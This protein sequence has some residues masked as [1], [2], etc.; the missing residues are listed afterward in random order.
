MEG[1]ENRTQVFTA[2]HTPLEIPHKPRDSHFSTAPTT[3]SGVEKTKAE[4]KPKT[5]AAA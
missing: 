4:A 3:A 5:K 1:G 2:S